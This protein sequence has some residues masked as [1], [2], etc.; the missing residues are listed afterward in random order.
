[1]TFYLQGDGSKT[2]IDSII[3]TDCK[4]QGLPVDADSWIAAKLAFG[5]EL[6]PLQKQILEAA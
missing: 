5:F 1:M 4:F 2:I 3:H 6:T